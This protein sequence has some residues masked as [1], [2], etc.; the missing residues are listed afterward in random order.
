M[1]GV[2]CVQSL[3]DDDLLAATRRLVHDEHELTATVLVHIG[4]ID[5]RQL[6][7]GHAFPSMFAFC[8]GELGFSEDAAY[9]RIT[10]A[11]LSR[12]LPAVIDAVR[13]GRIHLAG[14]RLLAPH[15]T[16]DNHAAVLAGASHKSKREIEEIVARFSPKPPVPPAIR[17]LPQRAAVQ[18]AEAMVAAPLDRVASPAPAEPPSVPALPPAAAPPIPA[19]APVHPP[20]APEHRP[21]VQPLSDSDPISLRR[22]LRL[23]CSSSREVR[24]GAASRR[25]LAARSRQFGS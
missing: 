11:R 21:I 22:V 12:R 7:L 2:D 24:A 9:N 18:T 20:H 16:D 1:I 15:L 5:E 4:E 14:L 25:Q 19:P 23:E 10:V 8:V 13:D 6:Y 17:K 3:T